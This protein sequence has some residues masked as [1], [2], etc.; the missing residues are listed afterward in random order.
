MVKFKKVLALSCAA[1]MV[2]SSTAFADGTVSQEIS[3]G[4]S[5]VV[6]NDNSTAPRIDKLVLPTMGD[7]TYDFTIDPDGLLANYDPVGYASGQSVYFNATMT[8]ATLGF[9]LSADTSTYGL[10]VQNKVVDTDAG[11]LSAALGAGPTTKADLLDG[12]ADTIL[13]NYFIWVPDTDNEGNGKFIPLTSDNVEKVLDITYSG[14]VGSEVFAS[15]T[16]NVSGKDNLA[17]DFI[18]DGKVYTVGYE[19]IEPQAAVEYYQP[20]VAD[21][22]TPEG[23]KAGLFVGTTAKV[24]TGDYSDIAPATLGSATKTLK[25][26]EAVMQQTGITDKAT[27]V[28]KSTFDIGVIAEVTVNDATGLTFLASDTIASEDATASVYMALTDGTNDAAVA[29]GKA[30]AY[31]VVKGT[32]DDA[33]TYQVQATTGTEA[34]TG[35]HLY[36]QYLTATQTYDDVEF[37]IEAKANTNGV[38][39]EAWE[40]YVETL[41]KA[42]GAQTK[43][44][45]D[46]VFKFVEIEDAAVTSVTDDNDT[47]DEPSDDTTAYFATFT[48][49][50]ASTFSVSAVDQPGATAAVGAGGWA[51]YE[52]GEK[53]PSI[54]N[55]TVTYSKSAGA[56]VDVDLGVGNLKA[57]GVASAKFGLDAES[58]TYDMTYSYDA[59]TGKLTLNSGFMGGAGTGDARVVKVTFNDTAQTA[60]ILNV[61]IAD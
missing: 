28:N 38:A 21:P 24:S 33:L 8:P 26:T 46:V 34:G 25:Y 6:E 39:K 42:E 56:V 35:S 16:L 43:P 7:N 18:W 51:T 59:Q 48:G 29:N 2:F 17:G 3:G 37:Q 60:V 22:S 44:S 32:G 4:G 45:I 52:A 15:A 23:V 10:Y 55:T 13:A 27:I 14:A 41:T 49:T 1:T 54:A 58:A 9:A 53:A 12:T 31:Y 5:S 19:D 36:K 57:T 20:A 40:T 50:D 61:T 30:T 11:K 47:P